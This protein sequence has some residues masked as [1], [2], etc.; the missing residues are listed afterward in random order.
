MR[1]K[2]PRT[3]SHAVSKDF[4]GCACS[5]GL[6]PD[7]HSGE[8]PGS[9]AKV[10]VASLLRRVPPINVSA[11]DPPDRPDFRHGKLRS[12][13]VIVEVALSIELLIATGLM[14]RT[15]DAL[16]KVNIGFDLAHV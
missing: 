11:S 1:P 8:V 4:Y 6:L 15:L 9:V 2:F 10:A 7:G 13:L 5:N 3:R 14:M 16:K 12:G